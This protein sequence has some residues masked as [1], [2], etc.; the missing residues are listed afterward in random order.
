MKNELLSDVQSFITGQRKFVNVSP[1]RTYSS[2]R[3]VTFYFADGT[4]EE[5]TYNCDHDTFLSW[6]EHTSGYLTHAS[7]AK[8]A[9]ESSG[10]PE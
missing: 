10:T 6:W 5:R 8:N 1:E 2:T 3:K 9:W 4:K 7:S